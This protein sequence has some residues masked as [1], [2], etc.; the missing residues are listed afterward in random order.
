MLQGTKSS[1]APTLKVSPP[2]DEHTKKDT[3]KATQFRII[4][5]TTATICR[6]NMHYVRGRRRNLVEHRLGKLNCCQW[7]WQFWL[8]SKANTHELW[9][10]NSQETLFWGPLW[11]GDIQNQA[12]P[13]V[14]LRMSGFEGIKNYSAQDDKVFLFLFFLVVLIY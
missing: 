3:T 4:K 8:L 13:V 10:L 11:I 6:V 12:F 14:M 7:S 1:M 5:T 9:L 2:Q